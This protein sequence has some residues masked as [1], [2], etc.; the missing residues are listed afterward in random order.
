MSTTPE[1]SIEFVDPPPKATG[2]DK[3]AAAR[4][5]A[6]LAQLKARPGEWALV[7]HDTTD[8]AGSTWRRQGCEV[9][10]RTTGHREGRRVVDVYAR[11]VEGTT[12]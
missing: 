8:T 4:N 12:K 5:A 2:N 11:W 9:T 7:K 3:R 1:E 6:V 10:T